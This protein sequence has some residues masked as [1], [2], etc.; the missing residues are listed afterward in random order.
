MCTTAMYIIASRNY[1]CFFYE[2]SITKQKPYILFI[3]YN[4]QTKILIVEV[5][6][7][8]LNT[9]FIDSS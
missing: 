8:D 5:L 1:N 4:A 7:Q 3:N 6:V 2:V 9:N